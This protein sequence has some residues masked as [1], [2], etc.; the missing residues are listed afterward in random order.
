MI[1]VK[2]L[3]AMTLKY[4]GTFQI[5]K[6]SSIDSSRRINPLAEKKIYDEPNYLTLKG[7]TYHL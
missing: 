1:L 2:F 5:L 4:K 6:S 3:G 7:P